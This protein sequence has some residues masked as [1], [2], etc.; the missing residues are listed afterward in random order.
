MNSVEAYNAG[1][2]HGVIH[3][4]RY[5]IPEEKINAMPKYKDIPKIAYDEPIYNFIMQSADAIS[6]YYDETLYNVFGQ[7][8]FIIK[9]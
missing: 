8:Q 6:N 1:F 2:Q 4:Q 7:W 3:C 5:G 9:K